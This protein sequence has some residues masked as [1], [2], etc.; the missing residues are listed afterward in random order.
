MQEI[1][2]H[3][4]KH[5]CEGTPQHNRV[6][7]RLV[8]CQLSE[9]ADLQCW[10]CAALT[11][12]TCICWWGCWRGCWGRSRPCHA[13]RSCGRGHWPLLQLPA[14]QKGCPRPAHGNDNAANTMPCHEKHL[15]RLAATA[16]LCELLP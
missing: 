15:T 1:P 16:R 7:R 13:A 2:R 11:A 6:S 5:P 9:C 12:F 3:D 4:C 14:S 8:C 10:H